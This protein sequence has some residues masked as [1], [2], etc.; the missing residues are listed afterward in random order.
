MRNNLKNKWPIPNVIFNIFL[1][2]IV[3][4]YIVLAYISLSPSVFGKNMDQFSLNRNT[5]K[6]VLKADRG[7][8]YDRDKNIL[9]INVSSYT[10]V[11][12]LDESRTGSSPTPQHVVDK[13]ET[14]KK[15][16]PVLN[17]NE[18]DLL[19]LLNKKLYQTELGINGRGITELKK[20]EIEELQLPGIG[21]IE[22]KK[23]Y[24]PNGDFAS[25]IVGYAKPYEKITTTDGVSKTEHTLVGELGIESKYN[26]LLKGT[27]GYFEY[28]RDRFGY[29][30]PDTKEIRIEPQD[31][32][33]IYLTLDSNIQRFLEGAIKES[34][35][36]YKPEWLMLT[37]MDA[38][39]G[40]ILG[41]TST[42]SYDPNIMNIT[43]YEN[44]LVTYLYEP[45]STM[46]TYTYMCAL[47]KGVYKGSKTFMSGAFKIGNDTVNDWNK[48]GWGTITFDKGYEYSSNVGIANLLD[49]YISKK[50]LQACLQKYGFGAKTDISLPRELT[51]SIRFN[52]EIEV[53]A[54]GFGQGIT[55]T[56][57]Q[58]LQALTMIANDG[59]MIKPNIVSKIVD[60]KTGETILEREVIKE[61]ILTNQATVNKI[62]E[63]MY[64]TVNGTDQS[65]TG[66]SYY[67]K[68]YDIIGKTGTSQVFNPNTGKYS[69]V[70]NDVI[71]SFAGMF[72][73]DDPQIIIYG[74]MKKPTW[75]ISAGL[76]VPTKA[77]ITSIAKHLNI[78]DPQKENAVSLKQFTM[79]SH[80]NKN[81]L[82]VQN[83]YK[84]LD[85]ELTVLGDG[86]KIVKQSPE[87]NNIVLAGDRVILVTNTEYFKI[88]NLKGWSRLEVLELCSLIKIKCESEGY[89]YVTE[90]NILPDSV[91]TDS[92]TLKIILS[93]KY[94]LDEVEE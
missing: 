93:K 88:P 85:V 48:K 8:I 37:V 26:D 39:T 36:K 79:P 67:L 81:I 92:E 32:N 25:Y 70:A 53:A 80:I 7:V 89:G 84:N 68:G 24:Y 52:Y 43:S 19:G 62:K 61:D 2:F 13:E 17:M 14:A 77:V 20:E 9:A 86:N 64:N 27:D 56:Q 31:G 15:L 35:E 54:A 83:Y 78:F 59:V 22:N 71:H 55:T 74:A 94:D 66:R 47:E 12:Y 58:H 44:P 57:V 42:P 18:E 21:F 76:S 40:D 65:T 30:I 49:Q 1:F 29:K 69:T 34:Q 46:K 90:Q 91:V 38:K 28:Q 23:R 60:R 82:D 3:I 87:A 72:P 6:S 63:L 73:K 11:A 50:D 51:G 10:V 75:G 4:L 5:V 45:G 16:A 33:D 41:S